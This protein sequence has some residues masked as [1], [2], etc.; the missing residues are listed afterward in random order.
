MEVQVNNTLETL[1]DM[2]KHIPPSCGFVYSVD[3]TASHQNLYDIHGNH[4]QTIRVAPPEI[5]FTI[6]GPA[7]SIFE[8]FTSL[9]KT[10][11]NVMMSSYNAMSRHATFR[12]MYHETF[13][14]EYERVFKWAQ[15]SQEFDALMEEELS[16]NK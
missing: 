16:K 7:I 14:E 15:Y 8:K 5:T 13:T 9:I 10:S 1:A 12:I 2:Q 3:D 6:S 11:E 4:L